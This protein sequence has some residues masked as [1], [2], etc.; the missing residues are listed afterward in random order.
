M[1]KQHNKQ[2]GGDIGSNLFVALIVCGIMGFV[3]YK[4]VQASKKA[5]KVH[6]D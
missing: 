4:V 6:F 1:V 3:V 2:T 5:D